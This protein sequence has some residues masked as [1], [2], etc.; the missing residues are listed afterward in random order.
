MNKME[1]GMLNEIIIS[2]YIFRFKL[3]IVIF[4]ICFQLVL[5]RSCGKLRCD[6]FFFLVTAASLLWCH[7]PNRCYN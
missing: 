7:L 4:E 5:S 1:L 2:N 3:G 6:F